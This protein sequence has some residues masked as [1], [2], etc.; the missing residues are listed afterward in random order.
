[1]AN[2]SRVALGART[3]LLSI[4]VA[5]VACNG[6]SSAADIGG[7]PVPP[8]QSARE[9]LEALETTPEQDDQLLALVGKFAIVLSK[10]GKARRAFTDELLDSLLRGKVTAKRMAPV[11][12]DFE[13]AI[14]EATPKVLELINELHGILT[15]EQRTKL[16]DSLGER[17]E[18]AEAKRKARNKEMIDELDIGF[19]QKIAIAQ[20][21]SDK[22]G[23]LRPALQK[24]KRDARA[25]GEA[26]EKNDF[27]AN[28]LALFETDLGKLY[29]EA[30]VVLVDTLG[31][32]LE[33]E[34]R[35]SLANIIRHRLEGGGRAR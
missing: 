17:F 20:A 28:E 27:D 25:A 32:E 31:P 19:G 8:D 21:M 2:M 1:M 24:M 4:I 3:V 22:M 23:D 14:R 15:P 7:E 10:S 30:V 5:L 16:V 29:L 11:R 26:F 18:A 34:Q 33:Y 6:A 12:A 13:E 35:R 9:A